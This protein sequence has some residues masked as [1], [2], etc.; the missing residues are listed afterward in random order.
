MGGPDLVLG[1]LSLGP[2]PRHKQVLKQEADH[3]E[4]LPE[5]ERLRR[6]MTMKRNPI[7]GGR[8]ASLSLTQARGEDRSRLG[9]PREGGGPLPG[10][11][12][13]QPLW[14]PALV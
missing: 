11:A 14:G 7:R 2:E 4:S 1:E 10:S 12:F 8:N 6:S 5:G 13:L 9:A 3:S